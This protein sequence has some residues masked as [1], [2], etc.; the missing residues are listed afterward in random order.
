[1]AGDGTQ[2]NIEKT[3]RYLPEKRSFGEVLR[4]RI[5]STL[6]I[7]C[8]HDTITGK[9]KDRLRFDAARAA[10][11]KC[12]PDLAAVQIAIHAERASTKE[13]IDA[14]LMEAGLS[15]EQAFNGSSLGHSIV[16]KN[17]VAIEGD[18]ERVTTGKAVQKKME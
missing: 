14:L 1:M 16:D 5:D 18:S 6:A 8:I 11:N 12:L 9:N 10:L 3:K 13:D 7:E 2:K 15:P 17:T 4:N